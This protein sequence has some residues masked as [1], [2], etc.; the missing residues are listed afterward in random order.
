MLIIDIEIL[1]QDTLYSQ[2]YCINKCEKKKIYIY[3]YSSWRENTIKT[4]NNNKRE[5]AMWEITVNTCNIILQ[6]QL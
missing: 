1:E 4:K 2:L 3:Y 6:C 5:E